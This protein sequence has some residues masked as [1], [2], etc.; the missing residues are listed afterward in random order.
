MWNLWGSKLQSMSA[1]K[2]R[3]ECITLKSSMCPPLKTQTGSQAG[4]LQ[5]APADVRAPGW[6]G[7]TGTKP[8]LRQN[9]MICPSCS[10][11]TSSPGATSCKLHAQTLMFSQPLAAMPLVLQQPGCMSVRS[12][13]V[14]TQQGAPMSHPMRLQTEALGHTQDQ[15]CLRNSMWIA[16]NAHD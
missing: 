12:K 2:L 4:L 6:Q 16:Q 8:H 15:W 7:C 1:I 3:L 9:A 14:A 13:Q 11:L 10:Q 5:L